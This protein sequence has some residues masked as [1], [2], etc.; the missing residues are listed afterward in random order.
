MGRVSRGPGAVSDRCPHCLLRREDCLC[1]DLHKMANTT[2]VLVVRHNLERHKPSN[3]VRLAALCLHNIRVVDHGQPHV[4]PLD[5]AALLAPGAALLFPDRDPWPADRPAPT[6][7]VVVD[8]SWRQAR[9]MVQSLAGLWQL[10]RFSLVGGPPPGRRLRTPP[11][12]DGMSTVEALAL[13]LGVLDGPR[14]QEHLLDAH[15]RFVNRVL[16]SKGLL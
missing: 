5:M 3:T 1:A 13:A 12:P 7:L 4:P 2:P 9:K 14:V 6:Q 15:A 16:A 8:G 11:H 10:P